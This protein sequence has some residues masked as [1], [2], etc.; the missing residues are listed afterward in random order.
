MK[1]LLKLLALVAWT[2]FVAYVAYWSGMEDAADPSP[3]ERHGH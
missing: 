1:K 2:I 3:E